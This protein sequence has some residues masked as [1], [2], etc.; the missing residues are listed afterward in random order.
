MPADIG[1]HNSDLGTKFPPRADANLRSVDAGEISADA[2]A[3]ADLVMRAAVGA[4]DLDAGRHPRQHGWRGSAGSF[5]VPAD[6]ECVRAGQPALAPGWRLTD[7]G[8][9]GGVVNA[10][11]TM[12]SSRWPDGYIVALPGEGPQR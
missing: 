8:S 1:S 5:P 6:I 4:A 2:E 7:S 12:P 11:G 3:T 9:L 10:V